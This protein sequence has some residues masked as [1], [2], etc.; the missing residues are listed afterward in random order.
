[1][2]HRHI[3][4]TNPACPAFI[5]ED[6]PLHASSAAL[7]DRQAIA[8]RARASQHLAVSRALQG[9]SRHLLRDIGIDLGAA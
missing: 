7:A 4:W 3:Y 2:R 5:A 6:P 9:L 1:M 8:G